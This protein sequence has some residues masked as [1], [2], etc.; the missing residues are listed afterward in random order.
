[1]N[2]IVGASMQSEVR[3]A[4]ASLKGTRMHVDVTV[5][6]TTIAGKMRLLSS[7]EM[8]EAKLGTLYALEQMTPPV[9][10]DTPSHLYVQVWNTTF[11]AFVVSVAVRNPL[12]TTQPLAGLEEWREQCDDDQ[13]VALFVKYNDL[14]ER[15]DPLGDTITLSIEEIA[16]LSAAAKK[17]H[18]DTLLSFGS[19]KLALFAISTADQPST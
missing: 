7:R 3:E 4:L 1:M 13:I 19:R 17:K 16:E 6:R 14:A 5:P 9:N 11:N 10:K 12:D 8:T 2:R 15:L 18:A